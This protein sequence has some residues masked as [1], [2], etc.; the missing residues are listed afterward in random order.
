MHQAEGTFGFVYFLHQALAHDGIRDRRHWH[1]HGV[2]VHVAVHL[3]QTRCKKTCTGLRDDRG[4]M[5]SGCH[6]N[7]FVNEMT[8][9]CTA[10][11]DT[12]LIIRLHFGNFQ[13]FRFTV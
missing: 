8:A 10:R 7:P 11:P 13:A 6:K 12:S 5:N 2:A 1:C 9:F 3:G 4:S